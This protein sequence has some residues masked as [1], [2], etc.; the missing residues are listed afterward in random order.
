MKKVGTP[1]RSRLIEGD[2][3]R[4]QSELEKDLKFL[5]RRAEVSYGVYTNAVEGSRSSDQT[6]MELA[7]TVVGFEELIKIVRMFQ[8]QL[9]AH[10]QMDDDS[11]STD[12][13]SLKSHVLSYV[14]DLFTKK[15]SAASHILVFMIADELRK[16]KPYAIPVRFMLYKSLTDSTLR[17]LC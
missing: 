11:T 7:W 4:L 16:Q 8:V 15:H 3:Q 17:E 14:K 12:L 5:T 1:E 9:S 6:M 13:T 2:V 10:K